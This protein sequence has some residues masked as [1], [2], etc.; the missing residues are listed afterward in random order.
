MVFSFCLLQHFVFKA[1]IWR[2]SFHS[3]LHINIGG[4]DDGLTDRRVKEQTSISFSSA[5]PF[6][7]VPAARRPL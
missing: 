7:L 3:V 5:S 1:L 2:R 6:T 4:P